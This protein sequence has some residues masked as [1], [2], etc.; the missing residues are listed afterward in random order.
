MLLDTVVFP[1]GLQ[2]WRKGNMTKNIDLTTVG[3]RI[4]AKRIAAHITQEE[5]AEMLCVKAPV[6]SKYENNLVNIPNDTL[7]ALVKALD[8]TASYIMDGIECTLSS[9]EKELLAL[10]NSLKN[11]QLK[12]V[13]LGQLKALTL[14]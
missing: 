4:K 8:T 7:L 10:F 2:K 12:K 6:I 5:L 13:A 9:D 11:D 3:G 14:I 1:F